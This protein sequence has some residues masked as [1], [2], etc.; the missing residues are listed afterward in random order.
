MR[1]KAVALLLLSG[2]LVL[3]GCN[4]PTTVENIVPVPVGGVYSNDAGQSVVSV[5]SDRLSA[6]LREH[7]DCEIGRASCRERV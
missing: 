5:P 3:A 7:K 4:E 2:M 6:W 1:S